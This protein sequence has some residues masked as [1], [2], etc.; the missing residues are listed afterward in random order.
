MHCTCIRGAAFL[1]RPD[2]QGPKTS[3]SGKN[4]E[5]NAGGSKAAKGE[6]GKVKDA[7]DDM[8]DSASIKGKSGPRKTPPPPP[9]DKAAG[10]LRVSSSWT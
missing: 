10:L 6:V 4:S 9:A 1:G 3:G 5:A 8:F 7:L 2:A